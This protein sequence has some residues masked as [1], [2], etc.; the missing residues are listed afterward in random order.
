MSVA[1]PVSRVLPLAC[2]GP[3]NWAC[4]QW[5]RWL[6]VRPLHGRAGRGDAVGLVQ[7]VGQLFVGPVGAVEPLLGGPLDDPTADLFRQGSGDLAGGTFGFTRTQAAEAA[8]QVGVEPALD[9]TR[10][11][12]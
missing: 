5:P 3:C 12:G 2:R 10:G 8:L 1:G 4:P 11:D 6:V 9:G 7:V